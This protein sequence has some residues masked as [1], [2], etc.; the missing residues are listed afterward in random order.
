MKVKIQEKYKTILSHPLFWAFVVFVSLHAVN[1]LT[2]DFIAE[3]DSYRWILDYRKALNK[4]TING[5]RQLFSSGIISIHYLTGAGIYDIF[6]YIF[7]FFSITFLLPLW[8]VA[9]RLKNK[10]FQF[11]FLLLPLI[12]P[13][14][15]LQTEA[16]RP[17]IMIMIF[18]FF[19]VGLMSMENS[20][21]KK[22]SEFSFITVGMV[23]VIG[24]LFHRAF[25]I[26]A[27]IW[28]VTALYKYWK[29]IYSNKKKI[30]IF[31]VLFY[32]W[33][34]KLEMKSM[35]SQVFIHG[36]DILE[37]IFIKAETNFNFPAKYVNIDGVQMGWVNAEGVLRYYAFYVGPLTIFILLAFVYYLLKSNVFRNQIRNS[38]NNGLML[39]LSLLAIFFLFLAEILPRVGNI[40]FLPERSWVFLG[41]LL[42]LPVY[43]ILYYVEKEK[44]HSYQLSV[45]ILTASFLVISAGGAIYVN[46]QFGYIANSSKIESFSWIK[47]NLDKDS[48]VFA[49][50]YNSLLKAHSGLS[51]VVSIKKEHIENEPAQ[52]IRKMAEAENAVAD[53]A[54][55]K[56]RIKILKREV[57]STLKSMNKSE[58][59]DNSTVNGFNN[60]E[61]LLNFT[62]S[63]INNLEMV[64]D[65]GEHK[66]EKNIYVYYSKGSSKNPYK[67]RQYETD[68]STNGLED[69]LLVL[70]DYPQYFEK[71]YDTRDVKIWK[72]VRTE[73]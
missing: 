22:I 3:K 46:K 61:D 49:Y 32:P 1:I 58:Y 14:I 40:A 62:E 63:K 71:I 55:F 10:Y 73:S 17:Q 31:T 35:L 54:Y 12:S 56:K 18:L 67:D 59:I 11:I 42:A 30:V 16:T 6:K 2:F 39:Y 34:E 65:S 37:K 13:T 4:N 51:D 43:Q 9:R 64:Y 38:L 44:S 25:V 72:I 52:N 8:L 69:H 47:N 53:Y 66:K 57:A 27:F 15:I 29:N 33:L 19:L 70:D 23:C 45:L 7:P 36:A 28:L 5:Y 60:I 24:S 50:G 21:D 48:L 20:K 41:I 26:F 68:Y